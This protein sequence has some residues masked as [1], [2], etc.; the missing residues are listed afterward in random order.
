MRNGVVGGLWA[1]MDSRCIVS[2]SNYTGS[3][4]FECPFGGN[5]CFFENFDFCSKIGRFL[6]RFESYDA[7]GRYS[8]VRG[9]YRWR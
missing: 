2:G 5:G 3:E 4:D 8:R 6:T 7:S 1:R 9:G